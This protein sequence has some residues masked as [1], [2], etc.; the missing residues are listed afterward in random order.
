MTSYWPVSQ[1]AVREAFEWL[2]DC[3][4]HYRTSFLSLRVKSGLRALGRQEDDKLFVRRFVCVPRIRS[5]RTETDQSPV[6]VSESSRPGENPVFRHPQ[7][8]MQFSSA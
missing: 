3:T 1:P 2:L 6:G 4:W 7:F 8:K 5:I